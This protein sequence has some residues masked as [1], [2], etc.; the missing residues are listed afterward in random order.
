MYHNVIVLS[1]FLSPF[2]EKGI[3][4]EKGQYKR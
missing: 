3:E 4:K 2:K 1:T